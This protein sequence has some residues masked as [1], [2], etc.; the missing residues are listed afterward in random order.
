MIEQ[1]KGKLVES[2]PIKELGSLALSYGELRLDSVLDDGVSKD[3]PI[4]GTIVSLVKFGFNL[5]DRLYFNK[6][7]KFLAEIGRTTQ[8]QRNEFIR[9]NCQNERLF[10]ETILLILE[11]SD[12]IEKTTLIGKIFKSCILGETSYE[13]TLRLSEMVNRVYWGDLVNIVNEDNVDKCTQHRLSSVGLCDFKG[14]SSGRMTGGI[15]YS[16]SEDCKKIIQI[17]KEE[18]TT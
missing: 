15:H 11:R 12:R 1:L 3:V 5:R 8:E 2:L 16:I 4:L 17:A 6:I 18:G 7:C 14:V 10:E 9:V 13:D